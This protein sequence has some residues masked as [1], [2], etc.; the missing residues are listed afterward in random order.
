M[1]GL[2]YWFWMETYGPEG[3]R[4]GKGWGKKWTQRKSFGRSA[5][6]YLRSVSGAEV[7][8]YINIVTPQQTRIQMICSRSE[9]ESLSEEFSTDTLEAG[10]SNKIK[11]IDISKSSHR[12][13]WMVQ[14]T[15][16]GPRATSWLLL[17]YSFKRIQQFFPSK[18]PTSKSI[19]HSHYSRWDS[20]IILNMDF[21]LHPLVSVSLDFSRTDVYS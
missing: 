7:M 11:K 4:R 16:F 5:V 8:E 20:S 10:H 17:A 12:L 6:F 13:D 15:R 1:N 3:E 21:F 19:F 2:Q 18:F 14:Q 9:G